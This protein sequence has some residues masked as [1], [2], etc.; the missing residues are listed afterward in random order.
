MGT[1]W[2]SH[3]GRGAQLQALQAK[4]VARMLQPERHPWKILMEESLTGY[5]GLLQSSLLPWG[6]GVFAMVSAF[7]FRAGELSP[8]VEGIRVSVSAASTT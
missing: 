3:G 5:R 7:Q 8:R 6:L 1:W 2:A 4:V